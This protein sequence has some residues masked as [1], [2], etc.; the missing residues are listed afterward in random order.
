VRLAGSLPGLLLAIVIGVFLTAP[1]RAE[2]IPGATYV[3]THSGGGTVELTVS[4][5]G[6]SVTSFSYSA[7]PIGCGTSLTGKWMGGTPILN[8]AFSYPA[9]SEGYVSFSGTFSDLQNVTGTAT[10]VGSFCGGSHPTVTWEARTSSPPL[11]DLSVTLADS[12][13]PVLIGDSLVY[14]ATVNNGGPLSGQGATLTERL[15]TGVTFVS[16]T[17]GQGTC[18]QSGGVVTCNLGTLANGG[19]ATATVT[20]TPTHE[21]ELTSSATISGT[22]QDPNQTNNS[23][24]QQTKVEAPCIVP[25]VK[26]RAL[27]AAKQAIA[28]SHCRTG[29]V[30]RRYS[31]K[32]KEG[33]V[34]SQAPRPRARLPHLAKVNLVVSR[35]PKMK[36]G[37]AG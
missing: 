35:G 13:D 27:P 19:S 15:P 1:A 29:K 10:W 36:F 16:A 22:R 7:L 21:G 3:G 31:K 4:A 32:V 34:I 8:D 23:A 17:A 11:A 33:R 2:H 14:T 28:R 26:G 37:G 9:Q 12:P 30:A 25:N 5:D 18:S 6:S 24:T 20:V